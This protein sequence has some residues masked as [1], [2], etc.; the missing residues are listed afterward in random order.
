SSIYTY[1]PT[2]S[3]RY[4][5]TGPLNFNFDEFKIELRNDNDVN[6]YSDCSAP[7]ISEVTASDA[8]TVIVYF[9][10]EV[11]ENTAEN[12]ANYSIT[13]DITIESASLHL[14]NKSKIVLSVS[15]MTDGT[16]YTIT[17]SDVEDLN[18]NSIQDGTADFSYNTDGIN[19]MIEVSNI[20]LYPNP[21]SGKTSLVFNAKKQHQMNVS[22]ISIDG[23]IITNTTYILQK[24]ENRVDFNLSSLEKGIYFIKLKT[25]SG[26]KLLKI[27]KN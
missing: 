20:N 13:G 10:E 2:E 9:N 1:D 19:E 22:L 15:E 16:N 14:L 18:G 23:K 7:E 8:T 24:G 3:V 4:T 12:T 6:V 5:I 25:P 21:T 11:N 27:V 26:E 17:I